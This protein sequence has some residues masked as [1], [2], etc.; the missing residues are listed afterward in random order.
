MKPL[1]SG[2]IIANWLL[3]IALMAS[4]YLLYFNIASTLKFLNPTFLIALAMLILGVIC[5]LGGFLAKPG[6]TIIAGVVITVISGYKLVVT[7]NGVVDNNWLLHSI[8]FA[9][10]FYFVTN[11][12]DK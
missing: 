1:K 6:L 12:N 11:G 2:K 7:F 8:P 10:G 3:R 5:I 9:I 4:L